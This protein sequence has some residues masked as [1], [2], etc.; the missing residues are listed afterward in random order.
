MDLSS[1]RERQLACRVEQRFG[2]RMQSEVLTRQWSH[3][4]LEGGTL[5]LDAGEAK[6]EDA[7]LVY[8]TPELIQDFRAQRARVEAVQRA[9]A[10]VIPDVFPHLDGPHRGERRRD[11]RRAWTTACRRAGHPGM[12]RHDLR[13]TAVRN[14]VRAGV[15]EAVAMKVTGHRTRAVFDRYNIVSPSDLKTATAK[16]AATGQP[17]E[18]PGEVNR[19]QRRK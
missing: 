18:E 11:F 7:R 6:N 16:L 2:W 9:L 5:R 8:L 12:L 14:L 17:G 19:A 10:R 15:S 1:R 13:R 3:V 4:D